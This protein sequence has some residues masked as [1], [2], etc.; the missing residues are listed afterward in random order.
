MSVLLLGNGINQLEGLAP[1]WEKLL[2]DIAKAHGCK[3]EDSLSNILS[4]EM[5]ENQILKKSDMTET[6]VHKKIAQELEQGEIQTKTDWSKTVHAQL[7]ALPVSA[8]LTTNYDYALERSLDPRFRHKYTTTETRYNR[9][10]YQEAGGKR[11][12]HIHGECAYPRSICLGYE[13]YAGTLQYLRQDIVKNTSDQKDGHSFLLADILRGIT[14]KPENCWVYDYFTEDLY[15]LGLG[16]DI[17]E[18]DLWWLLSYRS[19]ELKNLPI[20]NKIVYLDTGVDKAED[21]VPEC[22]VPSC[23][24]KSK[25]RDA[26]ALTRQK[27]KALL[28]AF[29]VEYLMCKGADYPEQYDFAIDYL[30][31]NCK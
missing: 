18:L 11:I 26:K 22:P 12:Y 8:I 30:K 16:L 31:M 2:N 17:S 14:P 10:R 4:Y 20:A 25:V 24:Y 1:A 19:K 29:D 13:Q 27:K 15:I 5:L 7:T 23:I 21:Q 3:S 6:D 9:F 28:T